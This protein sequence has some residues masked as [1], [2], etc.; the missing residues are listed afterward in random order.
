MGERWVQPRAVP[1]EEFFPLPS[2]AVGI[3]RA[4]GPGRPAGLWKNNSLPLA[5]LWRGWRW[6]EGCLSQ[7]Q[8]DS[9][10]AGG[11]LRAL[12]ASQLPVGGLRRHRGGTRR[13]AGRAMRAAC[14]WVPAR[15]GSGC[16]GL[17]GAAPPAALSGC[18][19]SRLGA[20]SAP[21]SCRSCSARSA[22]RR[23]EGAR[24]ERAGSCWSLL[25]DDG[26]HEAAAVWHVGMLY[27]GPVA[28]RG[29]GCRGHPGGSGD[30]GVPPRKSFNCTL[31][32]CASLS[33]D[34]RSLSRRPAG[35]RPTC[36]IAGSGDPPREVGGC[37]GAAPWARVLPW[38]C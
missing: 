33:T 5:S 29:R 20:I 3:S 38:G 30:T 10:A 21:A 9:G 27:A 11:Q 1:T 16:A 6:W 15:R 36:V 28:F 35:H 32:L 34:I 37:R 19:N 8:R 23:V 24:G 4:A 18:R 7:E 25:G 22:L 26:S 17:R 31:H 14:P 2:P 13:S 12:P